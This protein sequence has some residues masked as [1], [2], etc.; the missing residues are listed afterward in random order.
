MKRTDVLTFI[1]Q[2]IIVNSLLHQANTNEI[3]NEEKVRK[4]GLI[5]DLFLL[6]QG[7]GSKSNKW[8]TEC[9]IETGRMR[10]IPTIHKV[11]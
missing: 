11:Q 2:N 9:K 8:A 10:N 6:T 1:L 5:R 7:S 3:C 4:G